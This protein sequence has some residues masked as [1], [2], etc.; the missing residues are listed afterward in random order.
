MKTSTDKL[1]QA[2]ERM[3]TGFKINHAKD[4]AANYSIS[5]DMTTKI[6]AYQ[7]AEDNCAQGLDM[8]T[9][10]S[11]SLS[12]IQDKLERLRALA[13]QASNGTYGAQSLKAI[14]AEAN[15]LVD[16]IERQYNTTEYNGI[17]L[18]EQETQ[19]P[20]DPNI[21]KPQHNG[22]IKEVVKRDTSAMTTLASVDLNADLVDGTYSISTPEEMK[23]LADMT[24]A[25]LV[26]AGDEF[27]L[28]NDIDLS[29]YDNWTP[30]GK[31]NAF[32]GKVDGNGF[33]IK[34]LIINDKLGDYLGLFGSVSG[35]VVA[36]TKLE[37]V[38]IIGN[39][40]IGS[41]VASATYSS[42]IINNSVHGIIRGHANSIGGLL[43][44]CVS[45][46]VDYNCVNVA[47]SGNGNIGG[48][49]G[50]QDNSSLDSN[51][52]KSNIYSEGAGGLVGYLRGTSS[53]TNCYSEGS[54][55]TSNYA[56]GLI[57][58]YTATASSHSL[59]IENCVS[60]SVVSKI[61]NDNY[62]CGSIIGNLAITADGVNFGSVDLSDC[63]VRIGETPK[64]GYVSKVNLS[65]YSYSPINSYDITSLLNEVSD[66]DL[67]N[68]RR[69]L[70]VGIVS[71]SSSSIDYDTSVIIEQVN[72]LRNIGIYENTKFKFL[73]QNLIIDSVLS[74]ISDKQTELG[75]VQN[76]LESALDEISIKYENWV[77][78]R[79]TLRDAD[80]AKVSSTYIQQQI[81]QQASATLMATAN[82]SPAIALQLI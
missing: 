46:I 2:I 25:G 20:D 55:T 73:N 82:Q 24:N 49:V 59:I 71:D 69:S 1:N 70:Q 26:S 80:I 21:P 3:T 57:G 30:I 31:G 60:M 51:Y 37:N 29:Q 17:K 63:Y 67:V 15:A 8:I 7:V 41:L 18:F 40:M 11:E 64:F 77:S 13:T 6:G 28:A 14:N 74:K 79:S 12:L 50:Y 23:K 75:A 32:Y 35:A 43:G 78:S 9:T 65:D 72:L 27:V 45:G 39:Y 34:N 61:N 22:F 52:A 58:I 56:G 68:V 33:I 10:A 47:I 38:N 53:I 19:M 16:E 62:R 42:Q 66:I 76:R 48:I 36:N 44:Q 54:V 5:T 81:L 4:N